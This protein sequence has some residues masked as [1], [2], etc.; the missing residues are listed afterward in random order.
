MTT[1]G[2]FPSQ[3]HQFLRPVLG[4][5]RGSRT[6]CIDCPP[7]VVPSPLGGTPVLFLPDK[8]SSRG[9]AAA[10]S[11]CLPD[12][13]PFAAPP[14]RNSAQEMQEGAAGGAAEEPTQQ[15]GAGGPEHLPPE[16]GRGAAGDPAADRDEALQVSGCSARKQRWSLGRP[17]PAPSPRPRG[18]HAAL[19]AVSQ[20]RLSPRVGPLSWGPSGVLSSI[21]CTPGFHS[22]RP[23]C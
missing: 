19:M 3:P 1:G 11:R 17:G 7:E 9:A 8:P 4:P 22:P 14:P 6:P 10:P 16:D 18:P 13:C 5:L 21:G 15:A 23:P 20:P 12:A 2:L